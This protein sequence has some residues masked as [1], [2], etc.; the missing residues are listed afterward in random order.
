[1]ARPRRQ[2]PLPTPDQHLFTHGDV[3]EFAFVRSPTHRAVG[4]YFEDQLR[5]PTLCRRAVGR[6]KA[7]RYHRVS[8]VLLLRVWRRGEMV[9][10]VLSY[11]GAP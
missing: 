10:Q 9:A 8:D 11:R 5:I 1:M 6:E 4:T 7:D 3:V 2:A